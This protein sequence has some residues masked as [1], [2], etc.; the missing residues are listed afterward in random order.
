MTSNGSG[1]HGFPMAPLDQVLWRIQRQTH[2]QATIVVI[3]RLDGPVDSSC[4]HAWHENMIALC[5]RFACRV[6]GPANRPRWEP[7]PHFSLDRHVVRVSLPAGADE[8]E[9]EHLVHALT[10]TSLPADAAPW[11]A[12]LIDGAP[13]GASVYLLKSA[14]ALADGLRVV[15][16]MRGRLAPVH[17][18][19][20]GPAVRHRPSLSRRFAGGRLWYR[21]A[22]SV[23]RPDARGRASRVSSAARERV[24]LSF[25]LIDMKRAARE[26]DGTV[27]DVLLCA[28]ARAVL[29]Y[30]AQQG[31]GRARR[32][33][34]IC[35]V[36]RP[37]LA[38]PHAGN[39]FTFS[40]L[41]FPEQQGD[42]PS[43]L[44]AVKEAV[45]R[46]GGTRPADAARLIAALA[47]AL[48][49]RLLLAGLRHVVGRHDFMVTN[50]PA[51]STAFTI[52]E[53]PVKT[54]CGIGP[55]LG[56]AVLVTMVSYQETCHLTLNCDPA[57]ITDVNALASCIRREL[58]DIATWAHRQH[59]S[60]H[61]ARP[62]SLD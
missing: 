28:T 26:A 20:H 11:Q 24:F 29:R 53:R 36:G 13:D 33:T 42:I 45:Q 15:H 16:L 30:R 46:S 12:F 57:L 56:T 62:T 23:L 22:A 18:G 21:L 7:D 41:T 60:G 59:Q 27:N 17:D 49:I 38:A 25:P 4:L 54:V 37:H 39:N 14:H 43:A 9:L 8:E 19:R 3:A 48:S 10:Q 40:S 58:T 51:G 52:A 31:E 61:N 34:G 55:L 50:L 32:L 5:P 1:R 2:H 47:P 44:R 35:L 6:T